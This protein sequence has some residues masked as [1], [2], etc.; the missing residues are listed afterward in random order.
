MEFSSP[1]M[2]RSGRIGFEINDRNSLWPAI[3]MLRSPSTGSGSIASTWNPTG[4]G[5]RRRTLTN[6][7]HES[8]KPGLG[9]RHPCF[10]LPR[11]DGSPTGRRF[12]VLATDEI[13]PIFWGYPLLIAVLDLLRSPQDGKA[14]MSDPQKYR[15][16]SSL[17]MTMQEVK[18]E[19]R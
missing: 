9:R 2:P 8:A 7:L 5:R 1:G 17:T 3:V 11:S 18:D 10:G 15:L 12:R 6:A 4:S 13:S 19:H 14:T 16:T